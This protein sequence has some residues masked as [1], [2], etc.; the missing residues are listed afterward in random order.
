[1]LPYEAMYILRPDLEEDQV[2]SNV[3]KYQ[4][5]IQ[6]NGGEITNLEEIGSKRLAYEINDYRD[7]Y[8]VLM[9]FKA[10]HEIN[11]EMERLMRISDDVIRY[12][13]VREDEE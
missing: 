8:Y 5:H 10:N 12:L 4:S 11:Q 3:E 7:G 13:V 1:M 9:N 2:K 6:N